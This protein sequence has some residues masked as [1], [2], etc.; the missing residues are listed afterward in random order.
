VGL[1]LTDLARPPADATDDHPPGPA[2]A[3]PRSGSA[4]AA[5][6]AVGLVAWAVSVDPWG[7]R[8]FTT[9]RWPVLATTVLV[10]VAVGWRDRPP[11]P[12]VL[13]GL[14]LALLTWLALATVFA[15]DPVH[16]W[17][18]HPQRHLGFVAWVLLVL[19]FRVGTVLRTEGAHQVLGRGATAALAILGIS[20]V[21]DLVGWSIASAATSAFG[22]RASGLLG[23]PAYLGAAAVALV[24]VVLGA[25]AGER[26][27]IWRALGFAAAALGVVAVAA[28]QTRGAWIG[29]L[30]AAVVAWP[31]LRATIGM[32]RL[33]TALLAAL[34]AA[35]VLAI[36]T[37]LGGRALATLDA[38]D[39]GGRSR[40]DEWRVAAA[41][42]A[43]HP[44]VG[45]GPEGYRVAATEHLDDDYARRYGRD[46]VV[47]R[48]HDGVLDVA[49]IGGLPAAS[50]YVGLGALV[51]VRAWR[52]RRSGNPFVV[53]AAAAVVG[54]AV[55]QLVL[56]PV[57][58]I[59]PV[60]WLLAGVVVAAT[61]DPNAGRRPTSGGAED[62]V[63]SAVAIVAA[64]VVLGAG[65]LDVVA[66]RHLAAAERE[67][68]GGHQLAALAEADAATRLRPDSIDAWYVA[69]DVAAS[70]TSLADLDAGL[71]RV[72]LGVERSPLDPALLD[73]HEQL[74][75]ERA[76]RSGLP[77]D[78]DRATGASEARITT[79]PSNAA[80]HRRLG[81]VLA[82]R[83]DRSG[84]IAAL[85]RA[86]DLD[87]D[88]DD[89]RAA[90]DHVRGD[91]P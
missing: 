50:L 2:T 80:H 83:G 35:V 47:D 42:V 6:V 69:A 72:E 28:S 66:D 55:Q 37:P 29:L 57:A 21:V 75:T 1:T 85:D 56:F 61:S 53:G 4:T 41:V 91:G 43:D 89:A 17:L 19:A 24:P 20:G 39:G 71:D 40:L 58:E 44:I 82:A 77:A 64:V 3:L 9:A 27:R 86:L 16:A 10:A 59:D 30:A 26:S 5:V 88:D 87:P 15:V 63:V 54:Y 79:D 51:G 7:F 13:R 8:P 49:A 90:R 78:L 76:L 33:G 18:G 12:R 60:V 22:S 31:A 34:A 65:A 67:R 23:Q 84:A 62:R 25:A 70:G 46:V 45:V 73:L 48:A 38:D 52:V 68:A 81:L 32:R 11:L 74:L 14:G 36:F